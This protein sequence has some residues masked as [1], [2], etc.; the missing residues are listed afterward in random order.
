MTEAT[1]SHPSRFP[2]FRALWQNPV[3]VK[4]L[5]SRMRGRRAYLVLTGYLLLMSAFITFVYLVYAAAADQPF[6]PN[7]RQAGKTVFAAVVGVQALLVIFI[8]PS[9]TAGAISGEKERQ[10][11]NLLRTTLLP[12]RSFV[13]GKLLSALSYVFL[14]ILTAIPLQSIAFILGGV[15]LT[16]V[17]IAELLI[18]VS[19]VAFAL[20]GLFFS[21]VMRSTLLASVSTFATSLFLTFG[22]PAIALIILPLASVFFTGGIPPLLEVILVYTALTL[23]ATNLPA[24]IIVSEVFLIEEDALFFYS[25]TISGYFVWFF[26]PWFVYIIFYILLSLLLYVLTVRRV[27]RV[28]EK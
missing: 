10:T 20:I 17:L 22:L 23:A 5:R 4:E 6:G 18:F 26:S 13:T 27:R 28:P 7:P 11:Y 8:G 25:D 3:T 21:A 12:A 16:E 2:R 1:Q 15:S 19:A 14:L 9:F 24:T